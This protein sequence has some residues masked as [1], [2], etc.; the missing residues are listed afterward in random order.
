MNLEIDTV[1]SSLRDKIYG[2]PDSKFKE[3]VASIQNELFKKD[4]NLKERSNKVWSEIFLNTLDFKRKEKLLDEVNKITKS[5][6][7]DAFDYIFIDKP[8]KLSI[9]IYAG[10]FISSKT[11]MEEVYY[12]NSNVKVKVTSDLNAID[13]LNSI[14]NDN[15][16]INLRGS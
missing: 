1:I 9:Q 3:V 16:N 10:N 15:E 5:N 12:L 4:T 7:I 8:Q 11:E 13:Q 14:N 2:I 6:I